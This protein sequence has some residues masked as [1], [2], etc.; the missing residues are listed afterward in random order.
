[1]NEVQTTELELFGEQFAIYGDINEPLFLAADIANMI[2]YDPDKVNQM[3]NLVDEDEKLTDTIYR[4]GQ[5]REMWFLTEYGVYEL[6]MQSRKP[7][8]KK[9]KVG[10]KK[11]LKQIRLGIYVPPRRQTKNDQG[12]YTFYNAKI[13]FRNF[14]GEKDL[15]KMGR[16]SFSILIDDSDF[17]NK[18]L[19]EGWNVKPLKRRDEEEEQKFHVPV[20]VR[21]DYKP[22]KIYKI[23]GKVKTLL[24]EEAVSSLDYDEFANVDVTIVP[25]NWNVNGKSGTKAYVKTMMISLVDDELMDSYTDEELPFN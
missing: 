12:G 24:D 5:N 25:S 22:P 16:R 15:N 18:L 23:S 3:L 13:I 1:M 14:S 4:S 11:L 8:A 21:Y 7:L 17:A 10:I 2:E 20:A 9:F 6:L 19:N